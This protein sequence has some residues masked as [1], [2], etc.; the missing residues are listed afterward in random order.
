M[1]LSEIATGVARSTQAAVADWCQEHGR[2]RGLAAFAR[3]IGVTERRARSLLEGTA[4]RID[5]AEYIA[6]QEARAE[7]LRLR[8]ARAQHDLNEIENS[9][10]GMDMGTPGGVLSGDGRPLHRHGHL[11][12]GSRQEGALT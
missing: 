10:E 11:V 12:S 2:A 5:A 4:G 8:I 6:A 9:H 7:V 3:R 1:R